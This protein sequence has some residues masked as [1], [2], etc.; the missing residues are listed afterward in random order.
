MN[1]FPLPNYGYN[2]VYGTFSSIGL[3]QTLRCPNKCV[4]CVKA[5]AGHGNTVMS[6]DDLDFALDV[7]PTASCPVDL[8]G[9]GDALL[10]DDLP[11]RIARIKKV[12]PDSKPSITTTLTFRRDRSFFYDIF[13]AGLDKI[14]V[15]CYG[16]TAEDYK[17]LHG[18]CLFHVVQENLQTLG[19]LPSSMKDCLT[20]KIFD[21][22]EE[23]F[24]IS[25]AVAKAESFLE[26]TR[27]YGITHTHHTRC[28]SWNRPSPPDGRALWELPVPCSVIWGNGAGF[29]YVQVD[30]DI[31]PCC[32]MY[33]KK[34]VLGNL[35][36]HTLDEIF[37]GRKYRFFYEKWKQMR[38]GDIPHCNTCQ[39]YDVYC[40]RDE[41][42]RMAAW[43]A[44]ELRGQEVV[45]WGAGEAYR[46]YKSFFADC[47]PV[48]MLLDSPGKSAYVDDIPVY[49]P[50]ELLPTLV[51]SLPLVIFATQDASPKILHKLKEKFTSYKPT[52]LVVCPANA[53][54]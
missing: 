33:D 28:F 44:R 9:S 54:V 7:L 29:L 3:E 37:N 16:H 39:H 2:S 50:E 22:T 15:S 42:M 18:S 45:F 20:I 34:M 4:F 43:Q 31:V 32:L 46:A 25:S 11:E 21:N 40:Y 26:T 38:P 30:L 53:H 17:K 51:E 47:K 5:A 35:R 24:G 19:Q 52:R 12:W 48:A 10:V 6:L 8:S 13:A 49:R 23:F 1:V 27:S 41:L 14:W 36:T